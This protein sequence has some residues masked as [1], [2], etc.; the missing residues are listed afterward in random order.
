MEVSLCR[1]H[2]THCPY[3]VLCMVLH[4]PTTANF[5]KVPKQPHEGNMLINPIFPMNSEKCQALL[6]VTWVL[7][8]ECSCFGLKTLI[9]CEA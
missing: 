7:E 6:K 8:F 9:L 2:A 3:S 1:L 5:T 4:A